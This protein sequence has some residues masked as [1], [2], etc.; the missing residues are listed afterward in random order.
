MP[1][2]IYESAPTGSVM[3]VL[4]LGRS[5]R[6]SAPIRDFRVHLPPINSNNSEEKKEPERKE[7]PS[8]IIAPLV[9]KPARLPILDFRK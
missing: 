7:E 2:N 3:P 1:N 4:D 9:A 6:R 8:R 5:L